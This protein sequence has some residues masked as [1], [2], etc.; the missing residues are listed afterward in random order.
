MCLKD[1][2][3]D[4]ED[5]TFIPLAVTLFV[6]AGNWPCSVSV[7]NKERLQIFLFMGEGETVFQS[8]LVVAFEMSFPR[9]RKVYS[10]F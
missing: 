6:T 7:F 10:C 3:A 4:L 8:I 9:K 2:V 1:V 5:F